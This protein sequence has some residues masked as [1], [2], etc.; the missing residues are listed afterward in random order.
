MNLDDIKQEILS[1]VD[2]EVMVKVSGSRNKNMMYK[3]VI[4]AV[5]SNVFTILVEG[6]S[7]S[8]TYSDVAIGDVKIY[9]I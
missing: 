8:F 5:Y 7:K 1:L 6:I 2:R 4:N 3:G 9:H